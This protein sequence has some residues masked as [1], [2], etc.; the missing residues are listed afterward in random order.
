[1]HLVALKRLVV[2]KSLGIDTDIDSSGDFLKRGRFAIPIDLWIEKIVAQAQLRQPGQSSGRIILTGNRMQD[3][4]LI[5]R[6]N[7]LNHPG[8][9]RDLLVFQQNAMPESMIQ[10]PDHAFDRVLA[11]TALGLRALHF[12][13]TVYLIV[14]HRS[15]L[16]LP[17]NANWPAQE[18]ISA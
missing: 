3:T 11:G 10:I 6:F 15:I 4:A 16:S 18:K 12:S 9:Q 7:H 2:D 1:M 17:V 14:G 5:Q 13:R 8:A